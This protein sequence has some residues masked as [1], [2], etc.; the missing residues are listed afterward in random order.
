MQDL[1]QC[2]FTLFKFFSSLNRT[3]CTVFPLKKFKLR[4]RSATLSIEKGGAVPYRDLVTINIV[5]T[6]LTFTRETV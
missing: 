6:P 2:K 5:L 1:L 3:F 4:S